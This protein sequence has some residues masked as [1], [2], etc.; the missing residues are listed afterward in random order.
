MRVGAKIYPVE[1]AV[2]PSCRPKLR[3][4]PA[5]LLDPS[6][7]ETRIGGNRS[8]RQNVAKSERNIPSL[9]E[10]SPSLPGVACGG[11]RHLLVAGWA[12]TLPGGDR[13]YRDQERL[14]NYNEGIREH[15]L[16]QFGGGHDQAERQDT[17]QE[18]EQ[19][20][21]HRNV[22]RLAAHGWN[23]GHAS[24]FITLQVF[25]RGAIFPRRDGGRKAAGADQDQS[26]N[27]REVRSF[28]IAAARHRAEV[29]EKLHDGK[30]E[31]DERSRRSDPRGQG[32][33]ESHA[34]AQPREMSLG[35]R[36]GRIRLLRVLDT[37]SC[38]NAL[39]VLG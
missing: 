24:K 30:S 27:A 9:S 23:T 14:R 31:P 5:N 22:G 15:G 29:L 11:V 18:H 17:D 35:F 38:F 12:R 10:D 16:A 19:R 36:R 25:H 7:S 21:P 39:V 8:H 34:R 26:D 13:E 37:L 6:E 2:R 32:G 1:F 3:H 20:H 4:L 33:L 28:R